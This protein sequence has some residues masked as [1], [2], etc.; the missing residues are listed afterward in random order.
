M[1]TSLAQLLRYYQVG[2]VNT[3]FGFACYAGLVALGLNIF[4]AQLV[5]YVAGASFNYI[6]YRR[7]VFVGAAPAGRRF[8]ASYLVHYLLSAAI[9]AG[10]V[11]L[12]P[13]PY[14]AGL[15]TVLVA[16]LVNYVALKRLVFAR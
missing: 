14:L 8:A 9:L 15:V 4:A 1:A 13:S 11:R 5:A 3:G 16:S 10:L 12:I 6:T 2:L 7:F